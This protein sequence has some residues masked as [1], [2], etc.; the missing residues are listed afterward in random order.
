M[1]SCLPCVLLTFL[2][3]S[4]AAFAQE[5]A[6]DL[7]SY[8]RFPLSIGIEYQSLSSLGLWEGAPYAP[9]DLSATVRWPIP[10][11]PILQPTL[12]L[13]MMRFDSQSLEAPLTFDHTHWY[14]ELGL[15][16]AHRFAKNFEIGADVLGGITEAVFTDLLPDEGTI[17]TTNII[18]ETAGRISLNPSF[19]ISID[20]RPAVKYLLFG[21]SMASLLSRS[22]TETASGLLFSIGFAASFRFG[23][24]PD[25]PTAM[26]RSLRFDEVIVPPL[27]SAMQSYYAKNPAGTVR[28]TNTENRPVSEVR[29]SFYQKDYMDSPTP[30][31]S[32]PE[33]KPGE[34]RQVGLLASFNK[35]VFTTE[36][37]TPLTGEV[38]VAYR[39][40]GKPAEQRQAVTYDLHDK[41]AITWDDDR[42]VAA[43]ITPADSALRNYASWIRQACKEDI[44]PG[45]SDTIQ[46][47]MQVFQALGT[48]GCLYQAD[49]TQPF[50]L[51]QGN[52]QVVDSISFPRDTL[53]RV[54]GDCDDLTVLYCS[55]LESAGLETAFITVPGHIYAA[56][57]TKVPSEGY[58]SIHPERAMSLAVKGELWVP[59]EITLI[60]KTGFLEAWR[61]GIEEWTAHDASPEKRAFNSTRDAQELFRPVGLKEADLGLQYGSR[62]SVQK[63]FLQDRDKIAERFVYEYS[64]LALQTGKKEDYNKFGIVSA[65]FL[66]YAAAEQAF[67]KALSIDPGF[68]GA[69]VNIGNL[70][71]LRGQYPPALEAY[72]SAYDQVLKKALPSSASS[73]KLLINISRTYYQMAKYTEAQDFFAKASA[74]DPAKAKEYSYLA[75][76]ATDNSRAASQ[77]DPRSE[78]LFVEEE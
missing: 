5:A 9:I 63:G 74:M 68:T 60:G 29:I 1:K 3:G 49:P 32:L 76:R 21:E 33:L 65:Q 7:N 77:K 72:R 38:I 28:I 58:R 62:E 67:R 71:F 59:V 56:F 53:K 14:A 17:G 31:A 40:G 44:A 69:Q 54:T 43:F 2:I 30:C 16:V 64:T 73:M 51:A 52:P 57:N 46:L 35:E 6:V 15:T 39:S 22:S 45:Y 78:I 18:F 4:V 75:E 24:D 36:G 50:L 61:K 27:F 19:N 8:Y 11:F 10:P 12:K 42:K 66:Q 20:I 41:T 55:L 23:Q 48:I 34:S 25:A 70:L 13:G 47:G 26:I 37:V